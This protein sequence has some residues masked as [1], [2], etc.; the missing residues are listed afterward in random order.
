MWGRLLIGR[1]FAKSSKR[2]LSSTLILEKPPPMGVVTGPFNPIWVRSIDSVSSLGMYSLYFSKASAPA[3]KLSHSNFTPVA[4]RMR[5][6]ACVT[7]G[8]MPS[9]GMRVILCAIN[10]HVGTAAPAVQ[11]S[12]APLALSR[13]LAFWLGRF[14]CLQQILQLCHEFLHIFE[15]QIY[16]SKAHIGNFVIPSQ[17]AHD[18]L[19]QFA[20]LALA[21]GR[22]DNKSF[23]LID[24]LFKPADRHRPFFAGPH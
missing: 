7:S 18:Q 5:T 22:L 6:T 13:R 24:D 20:G 4:S 3:A 16:R 17:P 10:A 9:P 8:P 21:L 2:F 12:E 15:I 14:F 11:R 19:A 1:K 23:R